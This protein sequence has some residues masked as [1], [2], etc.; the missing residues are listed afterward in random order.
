MD[1]PVECP[2]EELND[3]TRRIKIRQFISG[4]SP[5]AQ[6]A[7]YLR[8]L[9]SEIKTDVIGEL[10]VE[11]AR[12]IADLLDLQD[13]VAC[14][15]VSRSWRN[16][17]LSEPAISAIMNRYCPFLDPFLKQPSQSVLETRD[18]ERLKI[19]HRIG[20]ANSSKS[21]KVFLEQTYDWRDTTY[22]KLDQEYHGEDL[23]RVY[24]RFNRK[25]D[26]VDPE[27]PMCLRSLYSWGKIAW[28][29]EERFIVV[30]S[31][32]SRTRKLFAAPSG[33]IAGPR[34]QLFALGNTLVVGAINNVLVAWDHTTNVYREKSIPGPVK[35]CATEGSKVAIIFFGGDVL[36]WEFGNRL[37][38]LPVDHLIR[39][40]NLDNEQRRS[41]RDN[42]RVFFQP[43]CD[44]TIF[45]AS[46]YVDSESV[47]RRSVHEFQSTNYIKSFNMAIPS[48]A[49]FRAYNRPPGSAYVEIQKFIEFGRFAIWFLEI[50]PKD[51]AAEDFDIHAKDEFSLVEF[52][53]HERKFKSCNSD[54]LRYIRFKTFQQWDL[55]FRL[56][57][58]AKSFVV[59]SRQ[60]GY[61][62]T[63]DCVHTSRLLTEY[64]YS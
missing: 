38:T 60:P 11:L 29:H 32:W 2:G 34:L 25:Q 37:L 4:L 14:L 50:Y 23:S 6:E 30:S 15:A 16:K 51:T 57:F 52:D 53:M 17:F 24:S 63:G 48:K 41:W 31:L 13:Y 12:Q 18:D 5:T 36:L 21:L 33:P 20:W 1:S 55:D 61:K 3:Y 56:R 45:L 46:G 44:S 58:H 19:L 49:S 8:R 47:L 64:F 9:V 35:H 27:G 40:H 7:R 10:P 59:F 42:L 39:Y 43:G 54:R 22:F 28:C 26:D 62:L